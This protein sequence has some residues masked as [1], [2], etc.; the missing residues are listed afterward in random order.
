MSVEIVSHEAQQ[1]AVILRVSESE[2]GTRF[3]TGPDAPLQLGEINRP[4]GHKI[5]PHA[6]NLGVR[7]ITQTHEFLH[8]LSGRLKVDLF[9]DGGKLVAT[10]FLTAGD[11]ILLTGGAHGFEFLTACHLIEVKQGPYLGEQ[12]KTYL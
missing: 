2:P 9:A 4:A 7:T 12:D 8:V 6:H 1:L 10:R 5:P 3:V 11:T